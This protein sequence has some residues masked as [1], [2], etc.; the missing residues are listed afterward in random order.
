M[1]K[2]GENVGFGLLFPNKE[3]HNITATDPQATAAV[4]SQIRNATTSV[5]KLSRR[6]N[7]HFRNLTPSEF[8]GKRGRRKTYLKGTILFRWLQYNSPR[9]FPLTSKAPD[10]Q[11]PAS[12][13]K[14]FVGLPESP[15][16]ILNPQDPDPF[17]TAALPLDSSSSEVMFFVKIHHYTRIWTTESSLNGHSLGMKTC[18]LHMKESFRDKCRL[19]SL[20]AFGSGMMLHSP[21]EEDPKTRHS[22]TLAMMQYKAIAIE[23]LVSRLNSRPDKNTLMTTMYLMSLEVFSRNL[24]AAKVHMCAVRN[25]IEELGGLFAIPEMCREY[26]VVVT[27]N[28]ALLLNESAPFPVEHW[29]PGS[30]LKSPSKQWSYKLLQHELGRNLTLARLDSLDLRDTC[31]A[32]PCDLLDRIREL[33]AVEDL[34]ATTLA[35][36]YQYSDI[37]RWIRLR[38]S[39]CQYQLHWLRCAEISALLIDIRVRTNSE[40]T[41]QHRLN[42]CACIGA[43]FANVMM[44]YQGRTG[45]DRWGFFDEWRVTLLQSLDGLISFGC[46]TL[47]AMEDR[48]SANSSLLTLLLWATVMGAIVHRMQTNRC[49]LSFTSYGAKLKVLMTV[50]ELREPEDVER[51]CAKVLWSAKLMAQPLREVLD[52]VGSTEQVL[53]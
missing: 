50:L 24:E 9:S 43:Y 51:T 27:T 53:F 37:Y 11:K 13:V 5:L 44:I 17:D 31:S 33:L 30:I 26:V 15:N 45:V 2:S 19:A 40:E 29:D 48:G 32:A 39:S 52:Q 8:R 34:R 20:L 3:G 47:S 28:A 18:D 49:D 25:M 1:S 6:T 21:G 4:V 22:T 46:R 38:S 14:I 7:P 10:S 42:L 23:V 35:N 36:S 12:G 41:E 16:M